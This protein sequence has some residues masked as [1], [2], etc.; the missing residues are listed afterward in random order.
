MLLALVG[1]SSRA[2]E[3]LRYRYNGLL[4]DAT[5]ARGEEGRSLVTRFL[6]LA[7]RDEHRRPLAWETQGPWRQVSVM[8]GSWS[9][10]LQVRGEGED[11][12][13]ISSTLDTRQSPQPDARPPLWLP[14]G[15][16]QTS[17]IQFVMPTRS[18]QWI[19]RTTWQAEA[20][21]QWL[22]MSARLRGWDLET[23]AG[24]AELHFRRDGQHLNVTIVPPSREA[25]GAGVVMTA[26]RRR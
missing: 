4:V 19:Y 16:V 20:L 1:P 15:S 3:Q 21:A 2:G 23:A 22:R 24:A 11:L 25:R 17:Q 26:W 6:A 13:V 18:E 8:D 10:V 14:P 9:R 5:V 12:E 7:P